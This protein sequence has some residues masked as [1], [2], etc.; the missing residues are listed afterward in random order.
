MNTKKLSLGRTALDFLISSLAGIVV[1]IGYYF[2]Q[3]SNGFAP[4]GVG[5]LATITYY[6]LDY[7]VS[8]ALLMLIFNIPIFVLLTIFVNR[9]LGI[10]LIIYMFVQSL[11]TELFEYLGFKPYCLVNNTED[12]EMSF[13]CIATGVIAGLGFSIMLRHFGASGGTYAISAIIKRFKP[14]ANI[15]NLAF[16]LDGSVVIIAFFVY[17]FKITPTICTFIN[18]FVATVVVNTA[19]KG[20]NEGF[21]FEI[22]TD[23]PEELSQE[24]ITTL[25]HGVT[26]I[27][28]M[29]MYSHTEKHLLV[30]IVRK[31]NIG[32]M[33]K[34]IK[35]YKG[36]F[37]SFST[38]N[39]VFGRF[40]K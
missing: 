36:T 40:R 14:A 6:L 22:I 19:I 1:A 12:F 2:F 9:M 4:G 38:V 10:N 17:G 26:E 33:M 31:K 5:G 27:R 18:L 30:C 20:G 16:F 7:K 11:S 8:W 24:I 35:K 37:A 21:K 15:A 28:A 34:I 25:K 29:G 39:E 23:K 32:S 3:N 13:A